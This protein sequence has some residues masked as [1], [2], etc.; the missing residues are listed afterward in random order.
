[1]HLSVPQAPSN[2]QSRVVVFFPL[3]ACSAFMCSS[4]LHAWW[5]AICTQSNV[6]SVHVFR[7]SHTALSAPSVP[8]RDLIFDDIA[9]FSSV[10]GGFPHFPEKGWPTRVLG[11]FY[12]FYSCVPVA[13]PIFPGGSLGSANTASTRCGLE[14]SAVL[15]APKAAMV[16]SGEVLTGH[17]LDS[18][19]ECSRDQPSAA[20]PW[21]GLEEGRSSSGAGQRH[22][23]ADRQD[24][25]LR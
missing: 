3:W 22:G 9:P 24:R 15:T 5:L 2:S 10:F 13:F 18:P 21:P 7:L 4:S 8:R 25:Q 11:S 23:A 1:M 20:A 17:W 12:L 6:A 16:A 14:L 19:F